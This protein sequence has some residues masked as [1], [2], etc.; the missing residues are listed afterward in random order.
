VGSFPQ[1][2]SWCG[3]LDMAGN[4]LE[5]CSDWYGA[6]YYSACPQADPTGPDAGGMKVMKGGS[7]ELSALDCRPANRLYNIPGGWVEK[8][9]YPTMRTLA[10]P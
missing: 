2:A 5:W 8:F 4:A 10:R 9:R 3:A 1:G 6:G 7:F